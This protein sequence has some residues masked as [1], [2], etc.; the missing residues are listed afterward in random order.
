MNSDARKR[1]PDRIA[2]AVRVL[3]DSRG[4]GGVAR[5]SSLPTCKEVEA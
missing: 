5:W 1:V 2:T 3:L 4:F